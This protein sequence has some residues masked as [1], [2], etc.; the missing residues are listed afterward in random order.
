MSKLQRGDISPQ[1]WLRFQQ[2]ARRVFV[3]SHIIPSAL[4]ASVFSLLLHLNGEKP[5]L[6]RVERLEYDQWHPFDPSILFL[7][8]PSLHTLRVDY[9]IANFARDAHDR[10]PN[11]ALN[12][13]LRKAFADTPLTQEDDVSLLALTPDQV[14]ITRCSE[15]R[16][17]ALLSWESIFDCTLLRGLSGLQNL[18][19]LSLSVHVDDEYFTAVQHFG[20]LHKLTLQGACH[21]VAQFI[22]TGALSAPRLR[23]L[24]LDISPIGTQQVH[25]L[26][27]CIAAVC[28][29]YHRS[30][31]ELHLLSR[32]WGNP[33]QPEQPLLD[34]FQPLLELHDLEVIHITPFPRGRLTLSDETILEIALA[35]PNLTDFMLELYPTSTEPSPASLVELATHCPLMR[36]L[37]LP[38][39][40]LKAFT[41][42]A[43]YPTLAHGL[44]VLKIGNDIHGLNSAHLKASQFAQFLDR[45]F[46]ELDLERSDLRASRRPGLNTH[47]PEVIEV[48]R[49]LQMARRKA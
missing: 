23:T 13:L 16:E 14:P 11:V 7:A 15:L 33:T 28:S 43:S 3:V 1:E 20:A 30:L 49:T 18:I 32:G 10:R 36:K 21:R 22:E 41:D 12:L 19:D 29:Q 6:P 24:H 2:Y 17:I 42:A 9:R 25:D 45:I 46:P 31:R 26:N 8:S 34:V 5:L 4:E 40:D 47:C 44:H 48:L 37:H 39:L 27:R 38:Y 35:F